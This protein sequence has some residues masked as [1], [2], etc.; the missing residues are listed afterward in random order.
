VIV[1]AAFRGRG[2]ARRIVEAALARAQTL[3]PAFALLFCHPDRVGLYRR[4]GFSELDV[5]VMVEQ[6]DGRAVMTQRTMWR[7]LHE[8][9]TWPAGPV[10]L[11]GLP[12]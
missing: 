5:E 8:H 4:L 9:A 11:H 7:P 3:G 12:F 1:N 6:P 2:L 10:V